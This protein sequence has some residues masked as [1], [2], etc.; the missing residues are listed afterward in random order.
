MVL[1]G[2]MIRGVLASIPARVVC[3]DAVDDGDPVP[4]ETLTPCT[5]TAALE[6]SLVAQ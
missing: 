4:D 1:T 3:N 5:C 2:L 6:E